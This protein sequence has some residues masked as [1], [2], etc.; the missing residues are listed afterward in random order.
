M[1]SPSVSP[2]IFL[3]AQKTKAAWEQVAR[4]VQYW[5]APVGHVATADLVVY[6]ELVPWPGSQH[7]L[8]SNFRILIE[9]V[10]V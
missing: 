5:S 10:L 2:W 3:R 6:G 1:P 4:T 7:F 9:H 8:N